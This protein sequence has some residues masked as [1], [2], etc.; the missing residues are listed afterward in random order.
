MAPELLSK[1][2][3]YGAPVD[4]WTCGVAYYVLLNSHFPF[5]S[6]TDRELTRKIQSGIYHVPKELSKDS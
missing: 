5:V 1:R 6:H 3:Y 4:I 2:E